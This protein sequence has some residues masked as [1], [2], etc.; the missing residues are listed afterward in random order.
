[1]ASKSEME[2]ERRGDIKYWK[3][4]VILAMEEYKLAIK[5]GPKQLSA[6]A[7]A[8]GTLKSLAREQVDL[9]YDLDKILAE[10]DISDEDKQ[11]MIDLR[12]KVV[13]ENEQER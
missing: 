6:R 2:C 13:D 3:D 1:M 9:E 12:E 7:L 10:M 5:G 4:R 11:I 8:F